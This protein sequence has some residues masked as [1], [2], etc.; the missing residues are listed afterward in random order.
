MLTKYNF[1]FLNVSVAVKRCEMRK[2][3]KGP[4]LHYQNVSHDKTLSNSSTLYEI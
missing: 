2:L 3:F 1:L 4:P